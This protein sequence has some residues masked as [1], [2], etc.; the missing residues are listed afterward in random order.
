MCFRKFPIIFLNISK[1][2]SKYLKNNWLHV[3]NITVKTQKYSLSSIKW[4][5]KF[6]QIL[7]N[8]ILVQRTTKL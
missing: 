4:Q 6:Q 7:G 2:F 5:H 1:F 8:V 3:I